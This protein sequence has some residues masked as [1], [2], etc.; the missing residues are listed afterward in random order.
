MLRDSAA[1]PRVS[2]VIGAYNAA[3]WIAATL[4]S[5]LAQ[6]YP[7]FD[8]VV[9]DDGSTDATREIVGGFGDRVRYV[10]QPNAG[11]AAARNTGVRHARGHY[12]A[13]LDA[14]DLWLP[15]K[16][17]EQLGLHDAHPDLRWSYTDAS[18]FDAETGETVRVWS[19]S[20]ELRE[21][22]VLQSLLLGNFIPF[23]SVVVERAA[24]EACGGFREGAS[25][26]I[27]E[28]WDLWL[29]IAAR[30]SVGCVHRPLLNIRQHARRKTEAMDLAAALE[31]RLG[32]VER[33]VRRDPERLGNVRDRAVARVLLS[34]AR[35][36]VNRGERRAG[37]A[38]L[39][40]ALRLAPADAQAWIH[41]GASFVPSGIRRAL[42][43]ARPS[44]VR[45]RPDTG[46]E[47]ST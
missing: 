25:A 13:F 44:V 20:H 43:R 5:V 40:R 37:R 34:V 38:L 8:L 46:S 4:E 29:R 7:S 27:S 17:S 9:V 19:R 22:D 35:K 16:L 10:H 42:R 21:G 47:A 31:A 41:L 36:H 24:F 23:S 14:D 33:A 45:T 32:H 15:G 39:W 12:L 18:V 11:S 26:R 28:D 1:A 30:Y 2:V 3:A 6:T